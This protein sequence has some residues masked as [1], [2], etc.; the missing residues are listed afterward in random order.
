MSWTDA[1]VAL[2]R[3][4]W[5]DGVSASVIAQELRQTR[6][7]VI[8]KVHRLKLAPRQT[9]RPRRSMKRKGDRRVDA[10]NPTKLI[11]FVKPK[12]LPPEPPKP[13]TCEPVRLIDM[14]THRG[15]RYVIGEPCGPDTLMC[16]SPTKIGVSFCDYHHSIAW[17]KPI[18]QRR[19]A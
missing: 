16:A 10:L 7:A 6:N 5:A 15:C 12:P 2:L 8:G 14:P 4:R 19:A 1:N 9:A 18:R 3:Q 17:V 11:R 13:P